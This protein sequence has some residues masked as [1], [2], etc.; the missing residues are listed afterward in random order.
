MTYKVDESFAPAD[1][2]ARRPLTVSEPQRF[3]WQTKDFITFGVLA[4]LAAVS[5]FIFLSRA[6]D[7]GTPVFDEKHYV[8]QAWDIVL[9]ST[10]PITGGIESNPAYGLVVHPP[11]AK[12]LLAVGEVFFGYSPLGWRV[13]T[14]LFSTV[15]VLLIAGMARRLSGSTIVAA[16]AGI[17]ALCDGVLLVA[18]RFG[19]L[20]I[21]LTLFVVAATYCFILDHQEMRE[22]MYRAYLGNRVH[23]SELGPRFGFRWWR[24]AAGVCLG[25]ALSVKWSGLYYMAFFGI[26]TVVLDYLLRR[27]YQVARPF[28]GTLVRDCFPAFASV[29]ILPVALYAWSWRAWFAGETS[30]YRH[31]KENGTLTSDKWYF[32]LPDS[33]A[34]WF[35]YHESVLKFHASLTSSGGH[36]HPWD[37]KPWSWLVASR[38]VL[39]YSQ[40]GGHCAGTDTCRRMIY[41][42]GMP[43][44]WWLTVPVIAWAL[45]CLIIRRD[46]RFG[47]PLVAFAAGFIPWLIAY[48]RQMYFFYA[49]PM[50]PFTIVL[51]ALTLGLIGNTTTKVQ[52][53]GIKAPVSLGSV[54][55]IGY[56]ALVIVSFIYFSPLFYGTL[57]T[58]DHYNSLMWLRSWR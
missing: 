3:L 48:D 20:D 54:I 19:M 26:M 42:F 9:S 52:V 35:Y 22:R 6:T 44:I 16:F 50:V 14:A 13:M 12:Q 46:R 40:T 1:L 45:W 37:S 11:L 53:P 32:N 5:R 8:P 55:T 58:E 43:A 49:I 29:V 27:R 51:I 56:L 33:I 21:F 17:I 41:L 30:V 2:K 36:S 31:A 38:P 15:T 39:Y 57:I 4:V 18:G 24:F 47:I 10:N 25:L 23:E 34:N 28:L 7:N